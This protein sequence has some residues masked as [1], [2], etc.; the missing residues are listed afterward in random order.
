MDQV[1]IGRFVAQRR[2]EMSLTQRQLADTLGISDKT[3]SKWETGNGLPEVSLMMPL[4]D[5]LG[6]SVN[7]L[8][9]GELLADSDYKRKAEENM[10]DLVREREESKKKIILSVI[11]CVLTLLSGITLI[12]LSGLL[13][14][15]TWLRILIIAI[16]VIVIAGGI[17]VAVVLDLGAGTYECGKCGTRFVPTPGAY[18]AGPHTATKR[19]LRCPNCGEV[20]YCKKRLTH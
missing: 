16:A 4:C 9:S 1:K 11:V 19:K 14:M 13:E 7:E 12:M 5:T 20:S 6:I 17:G 10:M 8:L 2:K 15:E 18:I 3:V